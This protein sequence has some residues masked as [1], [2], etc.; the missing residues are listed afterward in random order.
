MKQI[1]PID[2]LLAESQARL[3]KITAE[4]NAEALE[5]F[6]QWQLQSVARAIPGKPTL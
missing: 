4:A 5:E 6:E 1:D 2:R 3:D